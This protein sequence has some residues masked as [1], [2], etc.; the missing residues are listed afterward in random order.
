LRKGLSA[1]HF[2]PSHILNNFH[3]SGGSHYPA[4]FWSTKIDFYLFIGLNLFADCLL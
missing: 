3:F 1:I 2:F 4:E